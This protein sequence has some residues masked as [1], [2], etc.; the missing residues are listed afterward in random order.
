MSEKPEQQ[1][2]K[3]PKKSN[4]TTVAIVVALIA[5]ISTIA[6]ALIQTSNH[7]S[8]G[9]SPKSTSPSSRASSTDI[10]PQ[11]Y[12]TIAPLTSYAVSRRVG[13]VAKGSESNLGANTIWLLD[14]TKENYYID[15]QAIVDPSNHKWSA[16]DRRLGSPS[17]RLPFEL[18]AVVVVAS[19]LCSSTLQTDVSSGNTKLPDYLPQGCHPIKPP[20]T[21]TVVR[22]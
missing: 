21:V 6:V 22:N 20:I 16:P 19:P 14:H 13:F 3:E 5:A 10:S 11:P 18:T 9:A 7:S 1:P 12:V 2:S 17:D 15:A 4:G 8:S